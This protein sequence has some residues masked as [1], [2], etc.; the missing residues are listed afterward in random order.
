MYNS[1]KN[2]LIAKMLSIV[3]QN[4]LNILIVFFSRHL[5]SG[6]NCKKIL[7]TKIDLFC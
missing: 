3:I 4:M 5:R 6:Q 7:E 1:E 2:K